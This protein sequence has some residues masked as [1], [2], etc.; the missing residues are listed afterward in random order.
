MYA[1]LEDWLVGSVGHH[2]ADLFG[3]AR[4]HTLSQLR[5]TKEAATLLSVKKS[6]VKAHTKLQ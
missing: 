1:G 6:M 5:L 4:T 2:E 3:V